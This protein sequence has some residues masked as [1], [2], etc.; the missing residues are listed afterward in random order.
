MAGLLHDTKNLTG[1]L[2]AVSIVGIIACIST[3]QIKIPLPPPALGK[4]VNAVPKG[5]LPWK[6]R[7]LEGLIKYDYSNGQVTVLANRVGSSSALDPG[8]EI[9]YA[10]DLAIASD[11]KVYFTSCSN[12]VPSK[13]S[14]GFYDTF[15]AW[16]LDL[17]QGLPGGRLM[18][19]DPMTQETVVLAK[20]LYYAN[21]VALA[22]DESYL[23]LAETDRI[24]V[25]KYWIKGPKAGIVEPLLENLPGVP[26]GVS[27][28]P[29]GQFWV[30]LV[31]P[32]PPIAVLL[33]E[34]VVRALYAWLP[35]GARP[36]VKI[37][38]AVAKVVVFSKSYCP[39][40]RKAK[41]ALGQLLYPDDITVVE[42][43]Q[44]SDE[45]AS[46]IQA[47]MQELTGAHTVPRVF[48]AGH[49]VGGGDDTAAKAAS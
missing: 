36:P 5:V 28:A 45:D 46:A 18:V 6:P 30:G 32:V 37:W 19:Y 26:D 35:A 34:P 31:N 2:S 40:C 9:T 1:F 27:T 39:F 15:R 11:G 33:K 3:G 8:S 16:S 49:F 17:A 43:D 48:V 29:D 4:Y 24:R 10:N 25:V 12:I 13:N 38:G 44:M 42:L 47:V 14:Q 20:G 7:P 21:G 22:A 23:L 41:E